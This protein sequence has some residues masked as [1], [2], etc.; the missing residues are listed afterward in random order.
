MEKQTQLSA[1][2]WL[3]SVLKSPALGK[4]NLM[5]STAKRFHFLHPFLFLKTLVPSP[6][7]RLHSSEKRAKGI[8]KV[9]LV[10][11]TKGFADKLS[12]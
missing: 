3:T 6:S 1:L 10:V 4:Q 7:W 2:G 11:C 8:A 12:E 5:S 9:A